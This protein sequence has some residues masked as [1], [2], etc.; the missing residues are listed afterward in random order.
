MLVS[1]L[2]RNAE[3]LVVRDMLL[4][5]KRFSADEALKRSLVYATSL[6]PVKEAVLLASELAKMAHK[7]NLKTITVFKFEM[8]RDTLDI[9]TNMKGKEY[10][11][12]T[13]SRL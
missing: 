2:Q 4:L 8:A 12:L 1:I 13:M 11:E 9:L 10:F 7:R 5:G 6:S 3:A